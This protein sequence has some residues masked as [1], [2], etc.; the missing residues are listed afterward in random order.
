MEIF[1]FTRNI[2]HIGEVPNNYSHIVLLYVI[3]VSHWSAQHCLMYQKTKK[4][5]P[6]NNTPPKKSQNNNNNKPSS[7]HLIQSA[8][9]LDRK[10]APMLASFGVVWT[11][12]PSVASGRLTHDPLR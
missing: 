7:L 9:L 10:S 12:T 5:K 4:K 2:K 11:E 6:Q 3:I 1:F 8:G